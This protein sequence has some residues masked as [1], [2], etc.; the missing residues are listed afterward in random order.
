MIKKIL[1]PIDASNF[2]IGAANYAI[3]LAKPHNATIFLI[4]V[5]EMHPYYSLI[6]YPTTGADKAPEK[7]IKRVMKNWF[8]KIEE[9]AR[10]Q[11]VNIKYDILFRRVSV[12]GS[13][14]SY[15]E[16][17]KIDIIVIGTR[18][19]TGF[20]RLLVGSVVRGVIDH[21]RCP[22]LLVR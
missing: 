16:D 8:T 13:I 17:N 14:L 15:A 11:N 7:D 22:V 18:G 4:H 12:I 1:V 5:V 2:S 9:S 20:K 3:D 21:A 10:K 19:L 6:T